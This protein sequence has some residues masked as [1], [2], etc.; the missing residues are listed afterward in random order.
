MPKDVPVDQFWAL[1]VYDMATYAFIYDPLNRVGLS[2]RE[3]SSMKV[4]N[5]GSVDLNPRLT[6]TDSGSVCLNG[7]GSA[8]ST[9]NQPWLQFNW[10]GGAAFDQNPAGRAAFGLSRKPAELI[11]F[12]EMY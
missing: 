2:S 10:S 1:I 11:Y 7:A 5:D 4:N 8:A 9:A 12:R 3:R 6:A